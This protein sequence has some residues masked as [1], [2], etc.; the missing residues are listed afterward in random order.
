MI[1][2]KNRN[3]FFNMIDIF[4]GISDRLRK[5][6]N[7]DVMVAMVDAIIGIKHKSKIPALL[8][9]IVGI[10]VVSEC[11]DKKMIVAV[12]IKPNTAPIR[13]PFRDKIM[14]WRWNWRAI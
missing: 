5:T 9:S 8:I 14:A 10:S 6:V 7:R 4:Y 3:I 2:T 11:D 13:P 12:V 1:S